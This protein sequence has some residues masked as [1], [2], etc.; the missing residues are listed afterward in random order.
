MPGGF[1]AKI[2]LIWDS[3]HESSV[4]AGGHEQLETDD[5][6]DPKQESV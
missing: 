5:I 1:V 6:Q 4:I 2:G 3:P